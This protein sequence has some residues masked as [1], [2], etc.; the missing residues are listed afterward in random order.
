ML[1]IRAG[2]LAVFVVRGF[3]IYYFIK[4]RVSDF[5]FCVCSLLNKPT[6][7]ETSDMNFSVCK[8]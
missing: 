6:A 3:Y 2:R 4:P 1:L 5:F 8:Q 7:P